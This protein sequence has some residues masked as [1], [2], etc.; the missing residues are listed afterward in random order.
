MN[1]IAPASISF[2]NTTYAALQ[3]EAEEGMR[4]SLDNYSRF[5]QIC[6]HPVHRFGRSW[7]E[8]IPRPGLSGFPAPPGPGGNYLRRR[9]GN[10]DGNHRY[11]N[12]PGS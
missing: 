9:S 1:L 6:M 2:S 12:R 8:T 7:Y 5:P 11:D 10:H 3:Q 4:S